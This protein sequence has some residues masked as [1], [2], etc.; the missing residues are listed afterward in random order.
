MAGTV[1]GTLTKTGKRF[2]TWETLLAFGSA[3]LV[4]RLSWNVLKN[5]APGYFDTKI[6]PLVI[7]FVLMTALAL[8]TEPPKEMEQTT[9]KQ[10]GQKA[11]ITIVNSLLV[12]SA[13][14]GI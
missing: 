2:Y 8:F 14:V 1:K 3:T 5:V 7:S 12:Y 6:V 11:M 4:V 9:W 10:K 13:A